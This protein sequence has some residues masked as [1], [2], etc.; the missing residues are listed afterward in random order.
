M[1]RCDKFIKGEC[2]LWKKALLVTFALGA[3]L[4]SPFIANAQEQTS[5]G[6]NEI[7]LHTGSLLPNQIDGVTEILPVWGA[8]YGL[9]TQLGVVELGGSNV[10]AQGVDFTTLTAS[11]RGDVPLADQIQGIIYGGLDFNWYRPEAES[12]RKSVTGVHVGTGLMMHVADTFWLRSELKF[13]GGP[14]TSLYI[15]FGVVF[16][17]PGSGGT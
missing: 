6:G 11:L 15:G 1:N 16:R 7:S 2:R 3:I 4:A 13:M 12:E 9:G 17:A 5:S 8:R 14:G 10:H